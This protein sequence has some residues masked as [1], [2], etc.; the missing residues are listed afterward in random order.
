MIEKS[1]ERK[2]I[3]EMLWE[4]VAK[5]YG[6]TPQEV[7]EEIARVIAIAKFSDDTGARNHWDKL[8]ENTP[9]PAPEELLTYL[10]MLVQ[11]QLV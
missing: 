7:R 9:T 6:T 4:M 1:E 2:N 10:F 5:E 11:K 3:M 8:C